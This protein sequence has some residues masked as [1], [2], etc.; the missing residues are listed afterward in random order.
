MNNANFNDN[1]G[2]SPNWAEKLTA[3]TA[4]AAVIIAISGGVIAYYQIRE[5]IHTREAQNYLELRKMFFD[6]DKSLDTLDRSKIYKPE[7]KSKAWDSLKRYW[8]F[9]QTEW[10]LETQID[11][12]E[13]RTWKVN[14]LPMIIKSLDEPMFRE[15]FLDM[16]IKRF[17]YYPKGE[18]FYCEIASEYLKHNSKPFL[19]YDKKDELP[20][21]LDYDKTLTCNNIR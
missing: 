13:K 9:S 3:V 15:S 10:M 19:N 14:T 12:S 6:I 4:I 16:T 20:T 8:Y 11:P 17:K 1:S 18:K 5:V 2:H 7:D 21:C